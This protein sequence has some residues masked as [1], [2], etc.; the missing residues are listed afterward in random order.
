MTL[1]EI[2][3]A[4]SPGERKTHSANPSLAAMGP[5]RLKQPLQNTT[6]MNRNG[7]PI[8]G[9]VRKPSASAARPRKQFRRS[10]SMFEHPRDIF[11]QEKKDF[12][13]D[14]A[15][16]LQSIMDVDDNHELVLPHVFPDGPDCLPRI[17]KETLVAVLDGHY[18][19]R[20]DQVKIVD[21]RFEYEFQGGHIDGA[22]NFND[23][24]ALG[25]DLFGSNPLTNALLVFHC[26][27][28]AHRAPIM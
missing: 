26:E 27:Y 6:S 21:C 17:T 24:E 9:Q 5:P 25:K 28:S 22:E 20:Y 16:G 19:H 3:E 11:K 10:L 1:G 18:S 8:Y 14:Q 7:S 12:C 15:N 13:N 2:F 23:K 4:A